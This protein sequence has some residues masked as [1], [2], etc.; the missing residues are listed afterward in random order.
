M[1]FRKGQRVLTVP[2]IGSLEAV[3]LIADGVVAVVA[4]VH[5]DDIVKM[6]KGSAQE[7][8]W[9]MYAALALGAHEVHIWPTPH[10]KG[11][12]KIR[13]YPPMLEV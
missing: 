1:K 13:Y 11:E 12:L 2:P 5:I 6:R 8:A 9:P 7:Q 3:T 10:R 4:V